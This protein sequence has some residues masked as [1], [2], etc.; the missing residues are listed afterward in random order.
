MTNQTDD[1]RAAAVAQVRQEFAPIV[2]AV[3]L[4]AQGNRE[5][6]RQ[7]DAILDDMS[8]RRPWQQLAAALRR[9]LAGEREGQTLMVGL[10]LA[11][12]AVVLDILQQLG[13]GETAVQ[14][15]APDKPLSMS[16]FLNG[17]L[18][19]VL[20]A[21]RPGAPDTLRADVETFTRKLAEDEEA[22]PDLQ[23]LGRVLHEILAGEREPDMSGLP[24]EL[25]AVVQT[26]IAH[27]T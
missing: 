24:P 27:L 16:E 7:L 19:G 21:C 12:R 11:D 17:L 25:T 26:L 10:D 4:A 20:L 8:Q 14:A 5:M 6:A 15:G 13:A 18:N 1:P 23:A 22:P 9:I 2:Q 3:I